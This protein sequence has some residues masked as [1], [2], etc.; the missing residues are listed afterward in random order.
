MIADAPHQA[1]LILFM[2]CDDFFAI[3]IR[4][5]GV[6][7]IGTNVIGADREIIIGIGF[8]IGH[9]EDAGRN[10]KI[11]RFEVTEQK[12]EVFFVVI[13]GLGEGHPVFRNQAH[14]HTEAIS[15]KSMIFRTIFWM[16]ASF[17]S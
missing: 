2:I 7:V 6:F 17:N 4:G 1:L 16:R 10:S 14:T 8:A 11:S 9:H 15:L 13:L 3:F 5:F 12:F